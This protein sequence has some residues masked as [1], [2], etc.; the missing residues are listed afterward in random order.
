[1]S[2]CWD[3][4]PPNGSGPQDVEPSRGV[5]CRLRPISWVGPSPPWC[6]RTRCDWRWPPISPR[7]SWSAASSSEPARCWTRSTRRATDP[8]CAA[9]VARG[10][11]VRLYVDLYAGQD[12]GW[13]EKTRAEVERAISIFEAADD[14]VGLATAWRVRCN[15]D[16]L[17]LEFDAGLDAAERIITH[18]NA[19]GDIRQQRRGAVAYS[20]CAVQGSTPVD[21]AIARCEDLIATVEGDRR[22]EAVVQGA[23]AQLHAMNGDGCSGADRL[24]ERARKARQ[25]RE[26]RRERLDVAGLGPGGNDPRRPRRRRGEP[27]AGLRRAGR[28]R[29]DLP[30]VDDRRP[31]L[32]RLRPRRPMGGSGGDR[33]GRPSDGRARRR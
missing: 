10:R 15:A 12:A 9:P 19:A 3:H 23:L 29:R 25:A 2:R 27:A 13:A 31:A 11:L 24:Y 4:A 18:A 30:A 1:M 7:H 20:V 26:E 17:A 28:P 16:I 33:R 14:Q 21:Q 22:T 8:A 6:P 32:V 5:T